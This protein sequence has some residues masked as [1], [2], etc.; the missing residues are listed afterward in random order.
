MD[1]P[2]RLRQVMLKMILWLVIAFCLQP[3]A[4][5]IA[6][7][8]VIMDASFSGEDSSLGFEGTIISAIMASTLVVPVSTYV[9]T[10]PGDKKSWFF[11]YGCG[12]AVTFLPVWWYLTATHSRLVSF[13]ESNFATIV[14]WLCAIFGFGALCAVASWIAIARKRR[15]EDFS[16]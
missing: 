4:Y 10:R 15:A 14:L 2:L 11:I 12:S 8:V 6:C 7:V 13:A 1:T 9:V 5:L 16:W 3:L